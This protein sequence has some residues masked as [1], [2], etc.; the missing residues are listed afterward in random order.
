M[1][2]PFLVGEAIGFGW[3]KTRAHSALLFQGVLTL[4]ALQVLISIVDKVLGGTLQG[5]LAAF[6]LAVVSVFLG[7][8]FTIIVLKLA[9]GEHASYRD[10]LPRGNVV[11]HFF[12]ASSAVVVVIVLGFILFIIPGIYLLLRFSMVRFA[13]LEL[14]PS[15]G[16]H[17]IRNALR[18]ST[19][20]TEGVK[21]RLL[22]FLLVLLGINILGAIL[23]MVGLLVTI[24]VSALAYAHVYLKLKNRS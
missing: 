11:W 21:W 14:S 8:G 16:A 18:H 6:A 17:S 22:G 10:I 5:M 20:L 19:K 9:K 7:A 13:V 4:F 15:E 2:P 24:P 23:L 1:H 12:C 3:H